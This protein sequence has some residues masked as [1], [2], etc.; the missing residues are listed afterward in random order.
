MLIGARVGGWFDEPNQVSIT[1]QEYREAY[2]LHQEGKLK[3]LSFVRA[4]VW[5]MKD[6]RAE[7]VLEV[8]ELMATPDARKVIESL[9]KQ[10]A[11]TFV[12]EEA[13]ATLDRLEGHERDR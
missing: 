3:L 10:S 8:L 9:V 5:R 2:R 1:Q 12:A 13:K 6:D 11:G 7:R 4:D